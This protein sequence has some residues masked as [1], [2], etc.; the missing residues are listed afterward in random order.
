[1]TQRCPNCAHASGYWRRSS[2]DWRCRRCGY[3]WGPKQDDKAVASEAAAA[4]PDA[5][6][7]SKSPSSSSV[8][9]TLRAP[10]LLDPEVERI[11][12]E[13]AASLAESVTEEAEAD[14]LQ[15]VL[16]SLKDEWYAVE[17]DSI[18]EIKRECAITPVPGTPDY[19]AGVINLRG[20]I[21][22]V[23][24]LATLLGSA[25]SP[26]EPALVICQL[27]DVTTALLVDAVA[28]IVDVPRAAVEPPLAT[29]ER[30]RAEH[31]VGQVA[32]GDRLV[33]ILNLNQVVTP[34]GV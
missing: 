21:L 26:D 25:E 1:M 12:R 34:I 23:T 5:A 32:L 16:F 20:E 28:D 4:P 8:A 13:R 18:R 22:S 19:V 6:G 30:L 7:A 31:V 15:L 11:L 33:T 24:D 17:V 14:K 9:D 3:V 29:L 2:D 27:T 10:S